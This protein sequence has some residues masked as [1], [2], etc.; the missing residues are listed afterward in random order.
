MQAVVVGVAR[1]LQYLDP[2]F[3]DGERGVYVFPVPFFFF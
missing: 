1:G 3:C 2:E